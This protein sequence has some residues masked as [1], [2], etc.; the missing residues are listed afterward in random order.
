MVLDAVGTVPYHP[1]A[2]EIYLHVRKQDDKISRGTVYRNL[3][4]LVENGDVGQLAIPGV[5]RFDWR[6]APH[7][8]FKCTDCSMIY[9]VPIAYQKNLEVQLSKATDYVIYQHRILF[10]G[11][12]L[13]CQKKD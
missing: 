3:N 13:R 1:T 12:C 11:L 4:L 6:K 2:D 7:Y 10:E 5:H 8:H 9:D